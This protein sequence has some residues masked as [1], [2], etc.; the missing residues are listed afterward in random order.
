MPPVYRRYFNITVQLEG[1]PGRHLF[2]DIDR[3]EVHAGSAVAV[4]VGVGQVD[5]SVVI[6]RIA[7]VPWSW[8][9]PLL[10]IRFI[11]VLE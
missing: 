3:R 7:E 5:R 10:P 6:Q 4:Q 9:A 11:T 8:F 1:A 2:G